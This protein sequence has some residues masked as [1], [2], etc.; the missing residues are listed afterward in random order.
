MAE[1]NGNTSLHSLPG[2]LYVVA[3]PIGNLADITERAKLMLQ[4]VDIIACEDTRTTGALLSRLGL[5]HHT[6]VAYHEHNE[7]QAA[8][9]LVAQLTSGKSVAVVSDAG[10][11]GL[12]DP[13]FR[14]VRACRKR[15]L[16]VIPVPGPCALTVVL[17]A[18]GLPTNGFL[19]AGFLPPKSSARLAFFNKYRD[20]D[21]TLALYESCHRISK[22]ID[23]INRE[24]GASRVVCVA[25]EVTKLHEVFIV[26]P[27]ADVQARLGKSS[28][29]G[30]FVLLVAPASFAL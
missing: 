11:P 15:M 6:L 16:P 24:L 28:L 29:K 9:N 20:F 3:T 8:E 18:S 22:A 21:Y 27:V 25:R 17:C 14:L 26:G 1:T 7:L 12:S 4:Q 13:G 30:E 23:E 5:S 10:T 2:H 19:F